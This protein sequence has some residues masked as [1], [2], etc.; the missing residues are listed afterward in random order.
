MPLPRLLLAALLAL[1]VL[2]ALAASAPSRTL[3]VLVPQ[4]SHV[5]TPDVFYGTDPRQRFD[6]YQPAGSTAAPEGGFPMVVFFYGGS[7]TEGQKADYRYVGEALASRGIVTVVADYRLHPQVSYPQFLDDAAMALAQALRRAGRWR[8]DAQRVF[9]MGHSAG[10]YNAAMLALDARWLAGQDLTP[11]H[12]AG[13]IGLAGPYD[14]LPVQNTTVRPVFHHPNTPPESQPLRHAAASRLPVFLGAVPLDEL[15]NPQRNT[16]QL[17]S[18]LQASGAP[19]TLKWYDG[20]SHATLLG[21][22][23]RPLR[24][25]APVLD[26]VARFVHTTPHNTTV[27]AR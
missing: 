4:G 16:A 6:L 10:A 24:W 18:L 9:V 7:W 25:V 3:S 20:A 13:W 17:A 1:L 22:F 26:D 23:A 8:V 11:Q 5:F 27:A 19:V 14:F 12:L 21:A 2:V 15:V